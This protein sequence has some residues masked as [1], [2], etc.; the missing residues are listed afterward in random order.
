MRR[1]LTVRE[2]PIT[3]VEREVGDSKM[4]QDIVRE[5]LVNITGWGVAHRARQARSLLHR[6]PRWHRL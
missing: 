4:S 2:V 6:E 3:F 5:S 1:G